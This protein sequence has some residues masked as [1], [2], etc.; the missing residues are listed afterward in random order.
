VTSRSSSTP[1]IAAWYGMGSVKEKEGHLGI[2]GPDDPQS[3]YISFSA[4]PEV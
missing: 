4:V 3:L 1:R 2:L